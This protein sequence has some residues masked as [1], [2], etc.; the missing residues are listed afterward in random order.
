MRS[1]SILSKF[2]L[3]R[4]IFYLLGLSGLCGSCSNKEVDESCE[5]GTPSADYLFKGKVT[6]ENGLP[7]KDV[8]VT[9]SS[10]TTKYDS[11][12]TGRDGG[13]VIKTGHTESSRPTLSFS[14]E[15]YESRDTT[16]SMN[17]VEFKGG[18]DWYE[19]VAEKEVDI[20]LKKK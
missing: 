15:G 14:L 3:R 20:K 2:S 1:F 13:Y 19:G 17:D 7:L 9:F 18:K 4:G 12:K 5:Y 11:T 8:G 16:V 6:D 10:F